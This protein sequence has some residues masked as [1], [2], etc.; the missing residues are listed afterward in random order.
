[1][2][3]E[4][5]KLAEQA[6]DYANKAA[7]FAMMMLE[8]CRKEH[9]HKNTQTPQREQHLAKLNEVKEFVEEVRR[10]TKKKTIK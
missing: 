2:N 6:A 9:D 10:T 4:S 7:E 5:C 1:M 8:L 3:C